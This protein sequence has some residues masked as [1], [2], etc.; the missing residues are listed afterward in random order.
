M[1]E[2]WRPIKGYEGVYEVSN[3]CKARSIDRHDRR[4]VFHKGVELK[5]RMYEDERFIRLP[6]MDSQKTA[7]WIAF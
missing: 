4:G 6:Q 5:I 3:T 2:M 7:A 1:T